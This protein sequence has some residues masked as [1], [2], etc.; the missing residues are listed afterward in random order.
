LEKFVLGILPGILK[1]KKMIFQIFLAGY[2]KPR[3][4]LKTFSFPWKNVRG[5]TPL[6]LLFLCKKFSNLEKLIMGI[7]PGILKLKNFQKFFG[8]KILK[9]EKI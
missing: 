4:N 1:L 7:L 5:K 9:Q 2:F 8:W 6:N 3:K